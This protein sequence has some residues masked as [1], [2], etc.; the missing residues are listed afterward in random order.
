MTAVI[1]YFSG[2]GNTWWCA[3][4]LAVAFAAHGVSARIESVERI[5]RF[6]EAVV[7]GRSYNRGRGKLPAALG[8][9][10]RRPF[11]RW[12]PRL[13]DDVT[14]DVTLCSRC[15]RCALNCP[16]ANLTMTPDRVVTHGTCVL[17]LRCY[18]YC[19]VYAIRYM[20]RP[21]RLER[22]I[23]YRGPVAGFRPEEIAAGR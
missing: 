14:I 20:D 17:C 19:P 21:H 22:G 3:R 11:R 4:R 10:Q 13:R 5:D 12:F 1:F 8:A 7:R 15:G 23:P 6:A 18:S 9:M 2:T 16:S